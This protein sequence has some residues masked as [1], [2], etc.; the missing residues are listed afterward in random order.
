MHLLIM[1]G[2]AGIVSLSGESIDPRQ[3]ILMSRAIAHRGPDDEGYALI[4]RAGRT[5]T[6]YGGTGSC[7]EI[8]SRLPDIDK[9]D[10]PETS[11]IG[12]CHRRFSIIDLSAAAHQPFM[13]ADGCCCMTFNGEIYNYLEIAGMLRERGVVL[14]TASDTE[15]LL[16]SYKAWG[17]DCFSRMNGF[18]A[19][20]I[21]DRRKDCLVLSRDRI[22]KK[23]L[24]YTNHDGA[25]YF[26]SEIKSLLAIPGIGAGIT[27]N[28]SAA[29]IW[30]AYGRKNTDSSTFFNGI[31]MF[32]QAHTAIACEKMNPRRYWDLPA[33]RLTEGDV[34]PGEAATRLRELL[35]DSV[36][37]RLRCDVGVGIEL[38]GG[39]D[40]SAIAAAY[41]MC[42][43]KDI[44][45]YTV[46]F[47]G[48]SA[49]EAPLA[50]ETAQRLSVPLDILNVSPGSLWREIIKFTHLHEEPYH[51][52]SLLANQAMWLLMRSRGIKVS[53]NGAAGDECFGG[54]GHY[55]WGTQLENFL[56]ARFAGYIKNA[57][58]Y[59]EN[60]NVPFNAVFPFVYGL[61]RFAQNRF[62]GL[63]RTRHAHSLRRVPFITQIPGS[64]CMADEMTRSRMPYWMASGDRD[65]MGVPFEVRMPF[66]D[67]RIVEYAFTLPLTYL[68]RDGWQKWI[69]RK[70]FERELPASVVWRKRKAGFPFPFEAM[71][72]DSTALIRGILARSS[73]PF[74]KSYPADEMPDWTTISY[75]L[76]YE[77][78]IRRNTSLFDW[79]EK[80]SSGRFGIGEKPFVP[81]YTRNESAFT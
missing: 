48:G 9:F 35:I 64:A 8:R 76:W 78:F 41:S 11:H 10:F 73:N 74:V 57:V 17:L 5:I 65:S 67:Y 81:H 39:L 34:A 68:I 36:R 70:A 61:G 62:P 21:Y 72:R 16:E 33:Q 12:L 13:D 56:N 29:Y 80:E 42:G 26:A 2:I 28:E 63:R 44:G 22:G 54:Y 79:I 30:L 59:S 49:D 77:L 31:S 1:C 15:V 53:L 45:A 55:F 69:L 43:K 66:L 23:G 25:L 60:R 37:L 14:K 18:W 27:E 7:G 20:A 51:S 3:L 6:A 40:S 71:I 38:S 50:G 52:P 24:Y 75:I 47:G 4:N 32:P 58:L 46:S 19:C